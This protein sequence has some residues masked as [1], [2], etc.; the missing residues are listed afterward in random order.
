[1][2]LDVTATVDIKATAATVAAVQF[3]PD[4]DPEWIGGVDRVER[5]TSGPIGEGSRVR[6][7]GGFLGRPIVW[8]MHVVA[9]EP[10]RLVAMHAIES[11]FPMD[12]DYR[13]QPLG[14]GRH[15]RAS[16]RIRGEARGMYGMPGWLAGPMVKRSVE[17][18]LKR[19]KSIVEREAAG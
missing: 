13:L 5:V 3:D 15:T 16:I 4:R 17:G 12:V 14:D 2:P 10:D 7:L 1:M 11:P 9:F 19:L 18:D 8:L 6:R